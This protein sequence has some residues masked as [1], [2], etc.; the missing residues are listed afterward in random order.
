MTSWKSVSKTIWRAFRRNWEYINI[1]KHMRGTTE[2]LLLTSGPQWCGQG[3]YKNVSGTQE[4]VVEEWLE[5]WWADCTMSD[6]CNKWF[7]LFKAECN[8]EM[9]WA[10]EW[11]K[12]CWWAETHGDEATGDQRKCRRWPH[13]K[14]S[15]HLYVHAL[16]H[17]TAWHWGMIVKWHS[18]TAM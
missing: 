15:D 18:L 2:Q 7:C 5:L 13:L 14:T 1:N 4:C 8:N 10:A 12:K 6:T 17:S 11:D 16:A 9:K 3:L